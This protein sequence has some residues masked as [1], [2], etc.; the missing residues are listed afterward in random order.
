M[1]RLSLA[2]LVLVLA[3]GAV[4]AWSRFSRSEPSGPPAQEVLHRAALK[5]R[6]LTSARIAANGTFQAEGGALPA[7]GTWVIAGTLQDA[8]SSVQFRAD[9]DAIVQPGTQLNQLFHVRG[10]A[11]VILFDQ[12][13]FFFR[14][15]ALETDPIQSLFQPELI[16]LLLHRWWALPSPSQ[17]EG[18][19]AVPGGVTPP[20]HLLRM[21]SQVVR[22][23]RD[24]GSATLDG[25][26]MHHYAV[27]VDHAKLLQFFE[28]A[29]RSRTVAFDR[30]QFEASMQDLEATGELWID[31]KTFFLRQAQWTLKNIRWRDAAWSVSFTAAFTDINA[32][33]PIVPPSDAETFSTSALLRAP[34]VRSASDTSSAVPPF[35]P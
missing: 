2:L 16:A 35:I 13:E 24:V 32:A 5:S 25:D 14:I 19:I 4:F 8:G 33:P 23:K 10:G 7:S 29:A 34:F 6:E 17:P 9:A 18:A 20:P 22:V 3:G 21:Q 11:D 15:D 31:R 28:E 26:P 1:K 27:A 30:A 12:R